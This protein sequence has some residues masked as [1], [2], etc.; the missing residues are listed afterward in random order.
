[1]LKVLGVLFVLMLAA[2]AYFVY[3]YYPDSATWARS[4]GMS[5]LQVLGYG[6]VIALIAFIALLSMVIR[7]FGTFFRHFWKWIGAGFFLAAAWGTMAFFHPAEGYLA[8]TSFGGI[9]GK[10]ILSSPNVVGGLRVALLVLLGFLCIVP[11]HTCRLFL[12]LFRGTVWAVR[13]AW[14]G[15]RSRQKPP[16]GHADELEETEQGPIINDG[17]SWEPQEALALEAPREEVVGKQDNKKAQG[18]F[19]RRLSLPALVRPHKGVSPIGNDEPAPAIPAKTLQ[20]I[21]AV[22]AISQKRDP[23]TAEHS[24]RV[25]QLADALGREMQLLEEQLQ[26]IH[27]AATVHDIGKIS[28]PTEILNKPTTLSD[29]ERALIKGH[30]ETAH[31][32]LK[33]IELPWPVASLVLQ[34]HE[35]MNGSG[36][37]G[38]LAG[39]EIAKEAKILAVA[40]VMEAMCSQRPHRP[41]LSMEQALEELSRN[42]GTLYDPETVD[43]CIRLFTKKGFVFR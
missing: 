32:I 15:R 3:W 19:L 11:K 4:T 39:K 33:N 34:H 5:I 41:P 22:G 35:R 2:A 16:V 27:V 18:G 42:R 30:P 37:P 38:G 7:G 20:T 31:D 36:Y 12:A 17:A 13:R 14:R 6:L 40:D 8:D 24:R 26:A 43:A 25:T 10:S 23:S 9:V 29:Q 21:D 28:I 1:M